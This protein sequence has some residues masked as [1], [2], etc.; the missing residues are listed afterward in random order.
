MHINS[1]EQLKVLKEKLNS[2]KMSVLVGAGFSKNVSRVFPSW[3]ELLYDM[4]YFLYQNEVEEAYEAAISRLKRGKKIEKK[5][6][7]DF[8][9]EHIINTVGYLDIV[10]EYIK[11]KGYQEAIAAYIEEKTPKVIQVGDKVYLVNKLF[12]VDNKVELTADMLSQHKTLLQLPW[13]NIYTT[14]YDEMLELA[15]DSST[16]SSIEAEIKSLNSDIKNLLSEETDLLEKIEKLRNEPVTE[17]SKEENELNQKIFRTNILLEQVQRLVKDNEKNLG[18]MGRALTECLTLVTDSSQLS[19]KRNKNIIKLH[20]TIRSQNSTYGFDGDIR[21]HYVIAREDYDTYP[22]KHEAFTQLMRISL[23]QE[24]YCLIGF[25][26]VDTNFIGWI[27]WVRDILERGGKNNDKD[28][29]IYLV[30]ID[31]SEIENDKILFFENHR[32]CRIPIMQDHVID[33]L[34]GKTGSS[35]VDRK[36]PKQVIE[37]FLRYL[38]GGLT[39]SSPK[40][41]FELLQ[42]NKYNKLWDAVKVSNPKEVEITQVVKET[43]LILKLRR[44]K[45]LPSIHFAYSRSKQT[46]LY[47]TGVLVD[48]TKTNNIRQELLKLV[49][50]AV[51][52]TYLTLSYI[53][54]ANELGKILSSLR[55]KQIRR[56]FDLLKIRETCLQLEKDQFEFFANAFRKDKSKNYFDE[57]QY[58]SLLLSAFS[59]DFQKLKEQLAAWN[60][61]SHW[62]L[63]KAGILA[64]FDHIAAKDLLLHHYGQSENDTNQEQLYTL[65]LLQFLNQSGTFSVDKDIYD[66]IQL[67]KSSGLKDISENFDV[68]TGSF[69]KKPDKLKRY[70]EGRFSITN[71]V[72]FSNEFTEQQKAIQFIQLLIETG[73]PLALRSVTLKSNE[74]WYPILRS[75]FEHYPYP[76]LYYSLQYSDEKF[77]RRIGQDFAYSD[78]LRNKLDQILVLLLNSYSQSS[79]PNHFRVSILNF[80]SELFVAVDPEKWNGLFLQIWSSSDFEDRAFGE[81]YF[82]EHYFVKSALKYLVDADIIRAVI[83]TI[84]KY[85]DRNLSIDYLYNL[86]QST[87]LRDD[88][89]K[90]QSA[91]LAET[92][93]HLISLVISN[94]NAWL[95]IGNL[96]SVLSIDQR[97]NIKRIISQL[98]FSRVKDVQV[99]DILLYYSDKQPR[100]LTDLKS[101]ILKSDRLWDAGFRDQSLISGSSFIKLDQLRKKAYKPEGIVWNNTEAEE[102]FNILEKELSKIMNWLSKRSEN[103]FQFIL[104]EMFLFLENEQVKLRHLAD[105]YQ[106]YE[107][108]KELY[109]EAK[110]Y[111]DIVSGL[112]SSD[113]NTVK[114]ALSELSQLL[115]EDNDAENI[116][117]AL[118]ILINKILLQSAPCLEASINYLA[119]WANNDRITNKLMPYND[120][121]SLILKKYNEHE[122]LD[123][124]RPFVQQQLIH[125]AFALKK[126]NTSSEAIDIW[127]AKSINPRF[128]NVKYACLK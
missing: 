59:F 97:E 29:K 113:E 6:F 90:D 55:D 2:Q 117:T 95:M 84:A 88:G 17:N 101:A 65:Q 63:K 57:I 33:F 62:V 22:T 38:S 49:L 93:D 53:W 9:I 105:Y 86:S 27:K 3:W 34:I 91:V 46:L 19:V 114:W 125:I 75:V 15:N 47:Y 1:I 45:R 41:T 30:D 111:E 58:E 51:K 64:H 61:S 77:L 124:D 107:K 50:I 40:N 43:E 7:V 99:W 80:T 89:N 39:F 10:S 14:N 81:R 37:L 126:W 83:Q 110:G 26:G 20:G 60:P 102:I 94:E 92:I 31:T 100:T 108:V 104:K 109:I 76:V 121:L 120:L 112:L 74:I 21:K 11:R 25:S 16:A 35:I 42:Q 8:K 66:K 32:V 13:N 128:N 98:D 71:S 87:K 24:S 28:Y 18:L 116:D 44:Y 127:I 69:T 123:S 56:D 122:L 106:V 36:S 73:F 103:D 70:G 96:D 78:K 48:R 54:E 82:A 4:A 72:I 79:T 119:L 12:G 118:S 67:Y 85:P 52:D 68:I 5:N 115:F 23:L